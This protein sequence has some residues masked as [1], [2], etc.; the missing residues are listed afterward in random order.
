MPQ[1][2]SRFILTP[3]AQSESVCDEMNAPGTAT[4]P[5]FAWP[6]PTSVRRGPAVCDKGTCSLHTSPSAENCEHIVGH[7]L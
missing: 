1:L 3:V 7:A 6:W 5:G 4:I 2:W